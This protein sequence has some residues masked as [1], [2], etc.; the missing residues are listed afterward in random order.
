[1]LNLY[2]TSPLYYVGLADFRHRTLDC[3]YFEIN[4]ETMDKNSFIIFIEIKCT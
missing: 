1:M 4:N 3:G 2:N